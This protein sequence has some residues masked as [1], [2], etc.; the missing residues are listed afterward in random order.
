M[1]FRFGFC[2][3]CVL[4]QGSALGGA[5]CEYKIDKAK[6][7]VKSYQS[8]KKRDEDKLAKAK[9]ELE[10]LLKNCD[11]EAVLKEMEEYIAHTKQKLESARQNLHLA[12]QSNDT[13]QI[14]QAKLAHKIA[15]IQYIAARQEQLRLKDLLKSSR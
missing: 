13:H 6:E 5:V 1:K 2:F 4:W 11:D 9:N 15:H 10:S 7:G 12:I 8:Y 3:L 14:T